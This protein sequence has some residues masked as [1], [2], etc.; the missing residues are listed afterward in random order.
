[1]TYN[2]ATLS[3]VGGHNDAG[4]TRR[5]E[6]WYMVAPATGNHFVAVNVSIPAT[7]TVGVAVGVTTFTGADQN[8]PLG[9]F[10][11]GDGA[12]GGFAQLDILGVVNGMVIDT[13]ATGGD[14]TVSVGLGTQVQQWNLNSG[15][16]ANP[17]VT[18]WGSTRSGAPSVPV[19][20]TFS[21]TSN[22]SLGGVGINPST[23]DIG[24]QPASVQ[25]RSA[26]IRSTTS[27][28]STMVLSPAT[29][30]TLTD[31]YAATGLA[32]VSVTPGTGI[33]CP[34]TAP[35]ITCNVTGNLASG[36]SVTVAVRVSTTTAG[37]YP[38]TAAVSDSGTP[39]DP[40]T[41]N[42]TY[43]AL[44][45]VVSVVCSTNTL[46]AGGTLNGAIN[47]YYPGTANVAKGATS[48]PVGT[49]TGAGGTIANGSLLLVIQMQDASINVS[50]SVAYGNG[51]TGSGFTT[52][53]NAGNYEFVTATGPIA[54][55]HVPIKG[56]GPT[57]GL[58]FAYTAVAASGTKGISTYQVVLVPQYLSATLGAVTATPWNGSTGRNCRVGHRGTTESGR[59]IGFRRRAR[60]PWRRRNAIDRR[61]R[62]EHRLLADLAHDLHRCRAR[63]Y[64][65]SQRRRRCGHAG[66][67]RVFRGATCRRRLAILA[68]RPGRTEAWRVERRGM[69]AEAVRMR[70]RRRT[71]RTQAVVVVATEGRADSA[72]I[73]GTLISARG[74]RVEAHFPRPSTVSHSGVAAAG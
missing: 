17:D 62:C 22:W 8:V 36:A 53:N 14:Q 74:A 34:T 18:G 58:V 45:P 54:A 32:L 31:T 23:A 28:C 47:T 50:Q 12:A 26:R 5:V 41:G 52:I 72:A 21:G 9:A 56:A 73:R 64:R 13:L 7:A 42:N 61:N 19:S 20:E 3:F 70:I 25:Y 38:N 51:Y 35:T 1:M 65:C 63:W 49:A 71:T 46:V 69:R 4:G 57:N 11:S 6:M 2:G 16:T 67:G 37:F 44:A 60:F 55:G 48:I 10:V 40:N 43:V 30:V 33:T 24:L 39:P 27:P 59:R 15:N 68:V 66:V 29:G